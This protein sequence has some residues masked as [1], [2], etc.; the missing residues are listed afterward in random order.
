M[1]IYDKKSKA[2]KSAMRSVQRWK[3]G[4]RH[5]N[6]ISKDKIVKALQVRKSVL[7]R[8]ID[9]IGRIG[10]TIDGLIQISSDKRRRKISWELGTHATKQFL[11]AALRDS[12]EAY[13]IFFEQ[14]GAPYGMVSDESVIIKEI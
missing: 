3:D 6:K 9:K 12:I 13:E 8:R 10:V 2:Y 7:T 5:P 1:G 14:Y 11:T 4:T